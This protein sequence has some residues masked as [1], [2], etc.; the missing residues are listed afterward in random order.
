M[1]ALLSRASDIPTAQ[2]DDALLMLNIPRGQYHSLDSVGA[3]IWELLAAPTT[4]GDLVTRLVDEFDVSP[5][6]CGAEVDGFLE[7]LRARGLL[8]E[9]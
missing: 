7:E 6:Q 4:R 2:L 5:A 1:A 9:S 8:A 3:R